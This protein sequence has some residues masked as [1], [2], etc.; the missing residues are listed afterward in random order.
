MYDTMKKYKTVV[1]I[2]REY[3]LNCHR[4]VNQK[5]DSH[6]YEFHLNMVIETFNEYSY[7]IPSI[8]R[9]TVEAALWLHDVIEDCGQTYN[10]VLEKTNK[11]IADIVYALSNEKGRN[12]NERSN[13]KYYRGIRNTEY[14]DFC[15]MCDRIANIKYS[16][17]T[18]SKMLKKY[19]AEHPKFVKELYRYLYSIMSFKMGI[20]LGIKDSPIPAFSFKEKVI[21]KMDKPIM[22][23]TNKLDNL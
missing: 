5:Y 11:A 22:W 2:A 23:L 18:N 1:D 13:N 4:S 12:R 20:L 21:R 15:K 17:D 8:D 16:V 3:A 6:P 10:D 7:L 14:A 19:R 9:E